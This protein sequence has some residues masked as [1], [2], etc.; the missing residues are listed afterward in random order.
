[1]LR[2]FTSKQFPFQVRFFSGTKLKATVHGRVMITTERTDPDWSDEKYTKRIF[3]GKFQD[4]NF[5]QHLVHV[6]PDKDHQ[7]FKLVDQV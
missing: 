5:F 4:E 1:M 7:Y 2:V 3:A 6:I